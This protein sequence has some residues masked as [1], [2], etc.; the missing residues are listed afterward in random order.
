MDKY[1]SHIE[2]FKEALRGHKNV[3]LLLPFDRRIEDMNKE[4]MRLLAKKP[5]VHPKEC[6]CVACNP[7]D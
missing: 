1:D 6:G 5:G 3:Q 7:N 2:E 4:A